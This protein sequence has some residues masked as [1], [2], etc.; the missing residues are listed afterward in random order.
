MN[1]L[2]VSLDS[3]CSSNSVEYS[4]SVSSLSELVKASP[5]PL[6]YELYAD[7]ELTL[8]CCLSSPWLDLDQ[9]D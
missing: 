1:L 5:S 8:I 2:M 3:P 4:L 6:L 7:S 9:D